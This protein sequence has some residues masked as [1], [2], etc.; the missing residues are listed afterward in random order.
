MKKT[1]FTLL[2]SLL[3]MVSCRNSDTENMETVSTVYVYKGN[4][5]SQAHPTTGVAKIS[6]EKS[7]LNFE[8][9]K[10]DAGPNLN[11]YLASDINNIKGDYIDLGNIK[12]TSGNYSYDLPNN[13]DFDKYK[14]VVVWCVDFNVNFGY[15][16]LSK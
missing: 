1:I 14:Y 3:I 16:I 15:A 2:V 6:T 11:I 10:T 5:V 8:T 7:K 12:G 9:F 13:I 4:F